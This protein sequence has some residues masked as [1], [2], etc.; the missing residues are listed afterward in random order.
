MTFLRFGNG[1]DFEKIAEALP[2]GE[3]ARMSPTR[4]L[5]SRWH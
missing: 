2:L 1:R 4:R 5:R 3:Y